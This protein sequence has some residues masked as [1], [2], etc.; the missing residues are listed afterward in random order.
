MALQSF[1]RYVTNVER[2]VIEPICSRRTNLKNFA[3]YVG[4]GRAIAQT[5]DQFADDQPDRLLDTR[6]SSYRE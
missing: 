2:D 4:F 3:P 1:Y 6:L 5:D